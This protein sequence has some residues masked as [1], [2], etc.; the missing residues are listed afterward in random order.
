MSDFDRAAPWLA[1]ALTAED[2]RPLWTLED[3]KAELEARNAHLWMGDR[4]AMVTTIS[5]FGSERLIEAWLAGGE[6]NE[7]LSM[8]PVIEDWARRV[9]C[10][11]AHVTGRKGWVRALAPLGYETYSTT[12]R[13]LL[14]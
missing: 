10:T 14:A 2:D 12:V 11:Q 3:V 4:A 6:M 13:K 9:G 5:D 7:I 1:A 8:T